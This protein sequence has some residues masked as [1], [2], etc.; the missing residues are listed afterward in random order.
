MREGGL[1]WA[2]VVSATAF[3]NPLTEL[4][5]APASNLA[6]PFCFNPEI[7]QTFS[8]AG[9]PLLYSDKHLRFSPST[10]TD[11]PDEL[12]L[13]E[14]MQLKRKPSRLVDLNK[15]YAER[16]PLSVILSRYREFSQCKTK[17]LINSWEWQPRNRQPLAKNR[18][19]GHF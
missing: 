19:K 4:V 16:L 15:D 9:R 11:P 18:P 14:T 6:T 5:N 17:I 7:I 1:H 3:T 13:S 12:D 2:W 10:S 8:S